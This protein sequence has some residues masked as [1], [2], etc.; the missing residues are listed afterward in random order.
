MSKV[1][2]IFCNTSLSDINGQPKF[3]YRNFIDF[4]DKPPKDFNLDLYILIKATRLGYKIK[5]FPVFFH[6]R[7]FGISKGGGSL[8][9]KFK[10]S[11]KTL[12]Y[13]VV[14]SRKI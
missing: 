9:G 14:N 8:K 7:N 12:L 5:D 13:I 2:N 3:F 4:L 6:N 10:L 1:V 11:Y